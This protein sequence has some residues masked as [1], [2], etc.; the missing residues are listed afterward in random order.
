MSRGEQRSRRDL[1]KATGALGVAGLAG[2][3]GGESSGQE[4]T[5]DG[6]SET[7]TGIGNAT[8]AS[9]DA[10]TPTA[11]SAT[12]FHAGS[13]APPFSAAEPEFEEKYGV[14]VNRE[15]KG[16]V[17]S[18]KKITTQGRSADV[19]GVSDF[20]LI[21][22]MVVPEYGSWY[23]V[24]ATNAMSLQYREDSPGADEIGPDNWWEILSRDGVKVGHSDPAVDPGGY[25]AVM[26]VQLGKEKL[27]GQRLYD[28]Q[29]YDRIRDNM[30]VPTGTETKLEGQLK[31][32]KLDY[33]LY[34]RSI[35]SQSGL[36]HV[37]LQPHVDLSKLNRKYAQHYEKATVTAGGNE[38][39]GAPIAYG[40]TVPSVAEAPVRG[41]QWVE[42]MITD[43]GRRIL[44]NKG[45]IPKTPAVVTKDGDVPA[46]V[47]KHAEAKTSVGPL[48]L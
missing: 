4:T 29:T 20:R 40:I 23:A 37:D 26:A 39:V 32:G 11:D 12:V 5:T 48:E 38:Y 31:A 47:A 2:C 14:T 45:L 27:D 1:L 22:D 43:P 25:R 24:F 8:E 16:S 35:A 7:T 15:A 46:R 10:P 17:A 9:E 44:K 19:L 42:Y 41:A 34:Y 21:R 28:R 6:E 33:A 13:L 18:T 3:V 30:T 36:P